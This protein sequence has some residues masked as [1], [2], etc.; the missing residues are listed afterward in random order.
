MC[1][2]TLYLLLPLVLTGCAHKGT[3]PE[4][5]WEPYNRRVHTFNM[6]FDATFL[7][8]PA[9]L[10]KAV[11]PQPVRRGVNNFYTNFSMSS[12]VVNDLLQAQWTMAIKDT[13]RFIANTTIGVGG[14]FD[15]ASHMGLP[16]H[17]NDLGITLAK[18]G[19]MNSPYL[20]LPFLGPSTLR[21]TFAE[22]F[23]YA[24]FTPYPWIRSNAV[25]YS[26]L[27]VRYVDL[28]AQLLDTDRLLAE[29]LDSYTFMRDAWLQHRRYQITG[30]EQAS[31]GSLYIE[32]EQESGASPVGGV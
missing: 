18:W 10:Y 2:K 29:A 30:E 3:L 12:T 20:V 8:P 31:E 23:D 22:T 1:Q 6:A 9:R 15:P 13:W 24:L 4:D 16:P 17:V 21:D 11:V 25:L 7:K 26:L 28:R 32:D 19:D 27:G 14:I 5:P